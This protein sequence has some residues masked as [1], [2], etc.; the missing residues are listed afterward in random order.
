MKK[1]LC[2]GLFVIALATVAQAECIITGTLFRLTS[3]PDVTTAHIDDGGDQ[4]NALT[5]FNPQKCKPGDYV[6][7]QSNNQGDYYLVK[8]VR[9]TG[10]ILRTELGKDHT[11]IVLKTGQRIPMDGYHPIKPGT[12]ISVVTDC[13]NH[14]QIEE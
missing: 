4:L 1:I 7:V 8:S 5:V 10:E 9:I 13:D 2:T 6:K 12:E 14:Y 11:L 3:D